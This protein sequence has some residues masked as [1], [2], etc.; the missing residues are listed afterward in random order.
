MKGSWREY[1]IGSAALA[2][3][4]VG[5]A[6]ANR[7]DAFSAA[8]YLATNRLCM[9]VRDGSVAIAGFFSFLLSHSLRLDAH[10]FPCTGLDFAHL[11]KR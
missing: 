7:R 5:F 3:G 10:F 9:I 4:T 2:V 6:Y 1:W 11:F 8:V